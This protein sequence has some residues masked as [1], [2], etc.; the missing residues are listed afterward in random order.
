MRQE[1]TRLSYQQFY[2][3]IHCYKLGQNIY[4][5]KKLDLWELLEVQQDNKIVILLKRNL[6]DFIK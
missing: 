2:R 4:Q 1:T 3:L 5:D 6:V